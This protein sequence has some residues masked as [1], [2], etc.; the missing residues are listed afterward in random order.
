MKKTFGRA[1]GALLL[2]L[3]AAAFAQQHDYTYVE[4]GFVN[5]DFENGE[6]DSG[7]RLA[8][9][10]DLGAPLS[11]IG[12]YADTGDFSQLTGGLAF[13]TPLQNLLDF[14]AAV[15]LDR[16]DVPRDDDLAVGLRG[17]VRWLA[18]THAQ[19]PGRLEVGGELRHIFSVF[20]DSV[21]SV[22]A[23]ALYRIAEQFDVQGAFQVGDDDRIELGLRYSLGNQAYGRRAY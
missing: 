18:L 7:L 16:V 11:V 4:G 17:G 2:L 9:S 20:D 6:D 10:F 13:R 12:E 5:I 3:P 8:G 21:T 15:T 22:R 1:A 19:N 23:S 14:T